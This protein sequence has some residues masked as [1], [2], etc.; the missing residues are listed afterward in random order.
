MLCGWCYTKTL[1]AQAQ[2]GMLDDD[3]T[4]CNTTLFFSIALM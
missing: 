2:H 3:E 1:P 4:M